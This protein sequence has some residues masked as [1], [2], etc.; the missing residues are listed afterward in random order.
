MNELTDHYKNK[1]LVASSR[2]YW[3]CPECGEILPEEVTFEETHDILADGCGSDVE[4]RR[5]TI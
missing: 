3:F 4:W 5:E 2:D 1:G